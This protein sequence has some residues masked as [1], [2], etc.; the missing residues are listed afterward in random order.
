M[1]AIL[2]ELAKADSVRNLRN[3]PEPSTGNA[4]EVQESVSLLQ[5]MLQSAQDEY[6]ETVNAAQS[7]SESSADSPLFF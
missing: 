5:Q 2:A 3:A 4:N 7:D 6:E 1:K